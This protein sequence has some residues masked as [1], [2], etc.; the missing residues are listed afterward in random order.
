M[1]IKSLLKY[2]FCIVLVC[3]A[4]VF[5][6]H[7][8]EKRTVKDVTVSFTDSKSLFITEKNV[9]KLLIQ[10]MDS[11]QSIAIEK[12]DLKEGELRLVENAM[13]RDAD[14][15][16]SLDGKVDVV[17]EQRKPIARL[18]LPSSQMYLD[19]DLSLIHI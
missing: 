7:R 18:I 4:Y 2:S 12:L 15:S 1:K 16:V 9:N 14:V 17:V 3:S 19:I 5:A 8:F 13:V 11:V 10:N 6:S